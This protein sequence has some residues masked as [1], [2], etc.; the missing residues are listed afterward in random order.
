MTNT[1]DIMLACGTCGTCGRDIP[2]VTVP[3]QE[4]RECV[5]ARCAGCDSITTL[6]DFR[7]PVAGVRP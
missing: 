2:A 7:E 6:W 4:G 5:Q 3:A 1:N